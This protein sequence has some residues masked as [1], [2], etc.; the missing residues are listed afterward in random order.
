[1]KTHKLLTGLGLLVL[2]FTIALSLTMPVY[3]DG[4]NNAGNTNITHIGTTL[5]WHTFAGSTSTDESL[6][7]VTDP[8]E[9]VYVVGRSYQ[10]W[11]NPITPFAGGDTDAFIAKFDGNG[12]LLWNTFLGA[13]DSDRG[14]R[15]AIDKDN[16]LWVVGWSYRT[17]GSP[18]RAFTDTRPFGVPEPDAFVAKLDA[19]GNLLCTTFLGSGY[20]DWGHGI[21]TDGGGNVYITGRSGGDWGNSIQPYQGGNGE[22]AFVSKIDNS[23]NL[24]WNTFLGSTAS[25]GLD[26][27]NAEAGYGIKIDKSGNVI[28]AGLNYA[29]WG[30]PINPHSGASSNTE[31]GDIFVASLDP[32]GN[33]QWNTFFGEVTGLDYAA[34]VTT[35]QNGNVYVA[36]SSQNSTLSPVAPHLGNYDAVV[37]KLDNSGRE[38]WHT[39]YGTQN[40]DAAQGIITNKSGSRVC[41]AGGR[42]RSTYYGANQYVF[43]M[44]LD[45]NGIFLGDM[46]MGA[47]GYSN[48]GGRVATNGAGK[49]F[50]AGSSPNWGVPIHA[51]AG[52]SDSFVAKLDGCADSDLEIGKTFEN[53]NLLYGSMNSYTISVTNHGPNA[54]ESPV[55]EDT[56]PGGMLLVP[57][58]WLD[59]PWKCEGIPPTA[60]L[61]N[62][63]TVRQKVKC[64]YQGTLQPNT[65]STFH[66]PVSLPIAPL[67]PVN[68]GGW[69]GDIATNCASLTGN[70]AN[71]DNNSACASVIG[72]TPSTDYVWNLN[73]DFRTTPN[74]ENPNRDSYGNAGVWQFMRSPTLTR[75]PQTYTNLVHFE[76]ALSNIQGL[77]AWQGN[78][79]GGFSNNFHPEIIKN[80]TG[81]AQV[82]GSCT[83]PTDTTFM[84]PAPDQLAIVR[85]VSPIAG[86]ISITGTITDQDA[87]DG[88]GINWYLD[89]GTTSLDSGQVWFGSS[90]NLSTNLQNISVE[91]GESIY[92]AIDPAGDYYY[93]TTRID[94]TITGVEQS[95]TTVAISGNTG[96]G[97]VTLS[98]EN[99][100]N[101][102]VLSDG[103]GNYSFTIPYGWTG[104]VTP[105]KTGYIF[106]P[107]NKNYISVASD[108]IAQD[109][110]AILNTF[111]ISGNA[112]VG[113]AIITYTDGSATADGIGNYSFTVPYGWSGIVTP[114]KT[115]HTFSPASR[116]YTNVLADQ[117]AQDY[118]ANL[119]INGNFETYVGASKIPK[120]WEA[121]NFSPTDGK[122]TTSKDG[123]YSVKIGVD[124][125]ITK[126]LTQ[127]RNLGGPAKSEVKLWYWVKGGAL[128]KTR[129]CQVQIKLY[130]KT[131]LVGTLTV[132]CPTAVSFGWKERSGSL[133][134][135]S[136]YTKMVIQ[137]TVGIGSGKASDTT[138]NTFGGT[139]GGWFLFDLLRAGQSTGGIPPCESC[140]GFNFSEFNGILDALSWWHL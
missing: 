39:Y 23:C 84:H 11:G 101:Q 129:L 139:G 68:L 70:D 104:A 8:S 87:N 48:Y 136:A 44:E 10:S 6:G 123:K 22:D 21:T 12:N 118:I 130:N 111:T 57:D 36:G 74:Q 78:I 1:M 124:P 77:E 29:N 30:T 95:P 42:D 75:D 103:N 7:I 99:N 38:L 122:N 86:N 59:G 108:Q 69:N 96:I 91:I 73:D 97:G 119:I 105:S 117:T 85:W 65:T 53:R 14:D 28:V 120:S 89:K 83:F 16:N 27:Q 127:T 107:V 60:S 88:G 80:I 5:D 93:D 37:L 137:I 61:S 20:F 140:L 2:L 72:I 52:G 3:A 100:G 41:V 94:L 26:N 132:K 17:W 113:G 82:M 115:G 110:T 56:L 62:P 128:P 138:N 98:Y 133:T 81:V 58:P 50:V 18:K 109:Y 34:D 51:F 64:T 131:T 126:T 125:F 71:P 47:T 121:S 63:P 15:I 19:S 45:T 112:D 92:L 55:V 43:A 79:F 102:T 35:D 46:L 25:R 90:Q 116:T 49:I 67:V 66:L 13:I 76:P 4:L 9:N 54:V 106:S 31:N 40:G 134:A 114:Y 24:T 32:N 33:I 135:A